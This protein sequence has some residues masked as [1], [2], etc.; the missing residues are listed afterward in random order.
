MAQAT[1]F[2]MAK[3]DDL[4]AVVAGITEMHNLT[5]EQPSANVA[6]QTQREEI[7]KAKRAADPNRGRYMGEFAP[8]VEGDRDG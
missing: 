3:H 6:V 2:P 1:A 4:L 7:A 5:I 8:R